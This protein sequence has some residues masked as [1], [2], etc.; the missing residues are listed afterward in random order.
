M[1]GIRPLVAGNWKMN[2]L[3]SALAELR[4]LNVRFTRGPVPEADIMV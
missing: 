4:A 3:G 1:A 2:G